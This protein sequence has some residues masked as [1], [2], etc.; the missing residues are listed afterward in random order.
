VRDHGADLLKD[1]RGKTV[2]CPFDSMF[3]THF[4]SLPEREL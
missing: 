3:R 1:G 2:S 4:E